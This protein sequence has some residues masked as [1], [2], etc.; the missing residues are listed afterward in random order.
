M[1]AAGRRSDRATWLIGLIDGLLLGYVSVVFGTTGI[2]IL[3]VIFAVSFAIFRNLSLI[4][5]L[6]IGAGGIWTFRART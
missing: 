4:S 2:V 3:A 5:G 6:M 1:T